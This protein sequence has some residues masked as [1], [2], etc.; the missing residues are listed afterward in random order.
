MGDCVHTFRHYD[1]YHRIHRIQRKHGLNV[2]SAVFSPD[3]TYV[4]TESDDMAADIWDVESGAYLGTLEPMTFAVFS[5]DSTHVLTVWPSDED[6]E[7]TF[8]LWNLGS[9]KKEKTWTVHENH[10]NTAVFSP[11]STQVLTS[12]EDGTA[13]LWDVESEYCVKT[14]KGHLE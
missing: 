9:M 11:D 1:E 10:V 8:Q 12:S 3:S 13:K 4:L 5:P 2:Q 14:F 6:I 7:N